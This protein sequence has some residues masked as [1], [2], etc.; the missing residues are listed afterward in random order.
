MT[1]TTARRDILAAIA[2]DIRHCAEAP[3]RAA[4]REETAFE[5]WEYLFQTGQYQRARAWWFSDVELATRE[6][7]V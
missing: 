7:L 4:H 3:A 2:A 5:N 6:E 1:T